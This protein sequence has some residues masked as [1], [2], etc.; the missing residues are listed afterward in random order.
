MPRYFFRITKN[1]TV[2]R[3]AEPL[4]LANIHAAWE[5]A[6]SA[7]GELLRDL[8]GSLKIGTSWSVVVEDDAGRDLRTLTVSARSND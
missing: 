2:F 7:A 8:D 3:A 5:E 1:D 6:T 4:E